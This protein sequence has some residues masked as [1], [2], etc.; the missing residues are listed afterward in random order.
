MKDRAL[1]AGTKEASGGGVRPP[2]AGGEG[3]PD[4]DAGKTQGTRGHGSRA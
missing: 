3:A 1:E 2:R 4:R